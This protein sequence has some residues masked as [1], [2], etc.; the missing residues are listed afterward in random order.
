ST[1]PYRTSTFFMERPLQTD[2]A[3]ASMESPTPIRA[4]STIPIFPPYP[5][6]DTPCFISFVSG[7]LSYKKTHVCP[8]C[9]HESHSL[10]FARHIAS[11]LTNHVFTQTTPSRRLSYYNAF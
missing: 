1:S 10:R 9:I 8:D 3:N 4:N 7:K 11:L 2:A 6:R 5:P